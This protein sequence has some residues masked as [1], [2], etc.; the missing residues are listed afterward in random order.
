MQYI[1]TN[2]SKLNGEVDICGAKN[3]VLGLIAASILCED[4]IELENVPMVT[5]VLNLIESIKSIGSNVTIDK[6]NHKLIIDNKNIDPTKKINDQYVRKLRAS[7]YLLG[8]L[9]GRFKTTTVALPGGCQIGSRPIDI[10]IKAF[11]HL[12][13]IV[14]IQNGNIQINATKLI[15]KKIYL[16]FPSVGATINLILA[17]VLAEGETVIL[18]A[19]KEPHIVDIAE[20]L[21]TMGANIKGAGT[22]KITVKGVKKLH[23]TT[24]YTMPDQIEAGTFL[25]AGAISGGDITIKNV[26]PNHLNCITYKLMEMGC[27]IKY[28]DDK[29][30]I[31]RTS[32][33]KASDIT[34][35]PYPGFPTDMQPQMS[36]VLGVAK[37]TSIIK[38]TIF[39]NRFMYANELNRM[40]AKMIVHD[41]INV[42]EG[43]NHYQG[44]SVVVP[45]LRAGAALTIAALVADGTTTIDNIDLI[46]RGYENFDLKLNNLGANIKKINN[47]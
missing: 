20:F 26:I 5:D 35:L 13:G 39:E 9:L 15:G 36:A 40:G 19:A 25:A 7:Y 22:D 46:E 29:V 14:C 1:V 17:A 30:N 42:I 32:I 31:K 16:D 47:N 44:T 41:K 21:S 38:E 8:A 3:S 34:T 45:D 28:Y 33:L 37:G 12:G 27:D 11:E 23:S 24:Y 43:I 10:H 18:N 4:I 2:N 6:K